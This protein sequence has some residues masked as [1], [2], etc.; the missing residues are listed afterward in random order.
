MRDFLISAFGAVIGILV[1]TIFRLN[2][3]FV[4]L[5]CVLIFVYLSSYLFS[6]RIQSKQPIETGYDG[7]KRPPIAYK[8][9]LYI[10]ANPKSIF[11]VEY[12]VLKDT[13]VEDI[14]AFIKP[15]R[16]RRAELT[17][18][19]KKVVSKALADGAKS[20]NKVAAEKLEE[21][22]KAIGVI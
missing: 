19:A 10:S 7:Y 20:A 11:N 15:I 2:N 16:E 8:V 17:K 14:D 13:L 9:D 12:K 22:K 21:I 18:K 6:S 4:Y 1:A 5:A 3:T